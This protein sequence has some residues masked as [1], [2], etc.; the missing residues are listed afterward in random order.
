MRSTTYMLFSFI[1]SLSL[2]GCGTTGTAINALRPTE[3]KAPSVY[4]STTSY[5]N[6]PVKIKIQDIENKLNPSLNGLI[7]EDKNIED[8]DET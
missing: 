4:E 5:I 6:L 8:D 7:Y 3:D 1:I 2:N